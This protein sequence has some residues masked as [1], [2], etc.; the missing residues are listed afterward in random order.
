MSFLKYTTFSVFCAAGLVYNLIWGHFLPLGIGFTLIFFIFFG[1]FIGESFWPREQFISKTLF[2]VLA[3]ISGAVILLSITYYFYKIDAIAVSAYI[4]ALPAVIGV[5]AKLF[6]T[7]SLPLP[8]TAEPQKI[9]KPKIGFLF[10]FL[11]VAIPALFVFFFYFMGKARSDAAFVSPWEKIDGLI[12]PIYFLIVFLGL[13]AIHLKAKETYNL[14]LISGIFFAHL[15]VALIVYKFGYGFDSFIHRA[16][17]NY[18]SQNGEIVPKSPYYIG[19]YTFIT[20][21]AKLLAV[22]IDWVDKLL[23]PVFAAI[24]IPAAAF[25]SLGRIFNK[26][27]APL[28]ALTIL[29]IP[30]TNLIVTTPYGFSL[31]F[32]IITVFFGMNYLA[33]GRP[34][35]PIL[36]LLAMTTFFVHPITGIPALLFV[37]AALV[38]RKMPAN[39]ALKI[40]A[41]I[42]FFTLSAVAAPAA[43]AIFSRLSN[44]AAIIWK[45]NFAWEMPALFK[46][47]NFLLDFV[48]FYKMNL[49]YLLIILA[50]IGLAAAFKKKTEKIPLVGA[51]IASGLFA[52]YLMMKNFA[53]F[54]LLGEGENQNYA[55]RLFEIGTILLLPAIFF[56]LERVLSNLKNTDWKIKLSSFAIIAAV[57]TSSFYLTYPRRDIYEISHGWSVGK[58]HLEAVNFIEND[59]GSDS[60]IVLSDQATSAAALREFGFTNFKNGEKRHLQTPGG[61][62]FYYP[63]PLGGKLYRY[64]LDIMYK[65]SGEE[66][67]LGALRFANK[68]TGYLVIND[69]WENYK[70]IKYEFLNQGLPLKEIDKKTAIFKIEIK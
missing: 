37:F 5:A 31:A 28:L 38:F 53:T 44:A 29:A 49:F 30:L 40:S 22:K 21:L 65:N 14:A 11:N 27:A 63:I 48:Y 7:K 32:F 1:W 35:F 68:K 46:R 57:I 19:Q 18:I 23:L 41:G 55:D 34:A 10:F 6:G 47:F 51:I 33:S 17:E 70:K 64:Y 66:G 24:Y 50:G 12:L 3:I 42:I 25:W 15:G 9:I 2:G 45:W 36:F 39:R 61:E 8:Q 16:A 58:N 4:I 56:A 52:S 20:A 13:L 60:Y 59:A 54:P 69:Y 67:L 26:K 43:L 62:I